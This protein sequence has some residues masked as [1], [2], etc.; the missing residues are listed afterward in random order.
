MVNSPEEIAERISE[1]RVSCI[2]TSIMQEKTDN[3]ILIEYRFPLLVIIILMVFQQFTGG[4]VIRNYAPE[5]FEE[6][7][8]GSSASLL[9]NFVLGIIKVIVTAW[10][11]YKVRRIYIYIVWDIL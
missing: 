7:G 4:V 2:N 11:I 9:F 5:I 10:A 8:F 1:Y 6:A 3:E